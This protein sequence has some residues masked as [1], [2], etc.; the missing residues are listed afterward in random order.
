M[1]SSND[2]VETGNSTNDDLARTGAMMRPPAHVPIDDEGICHILPCNIDFTGS[3]NGSQFK[4]QAVAWKSTV[5]NTPQNKKTQNNEDAVATVDAVCVR[6]YGML[7]QAP[8]KSLNLSSKDH[9]KAN[10]DAKDD[11]SNKKNNSTKEHLGHPFPEV[12]GCVFEVQE[13]GNGTVLLEE[14]ALRFTSVQEWHHEH[15]VEAVTLKSSR[16]DDAMDWC[17]VANALHTPLPVAEE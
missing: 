14:R 6:G 1:S 8:A 4:P 9:D 16:F 15:I 12:A 10:K 2:A 13:N 17:V 3:V 7:A 5:D 11:N